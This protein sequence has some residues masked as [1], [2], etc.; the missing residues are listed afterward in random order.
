M[1]LMPAGRGA[2]SAAGKGG[3]GTWTPLNLPALAIWL[4]AND[5]ATITQSTGIVSAWNDKSTGGTYDVSQATS[6]NRPTYNANGL[7]SGKPAIVFASASA[8]KL[9]FPSLTSAGWTSGEILYVVKHTADPPAA[10]AASGSPIC[11][12]NF[13]LNPNSHEPYTDGIC[14]IRGLCSTTRH[15]VG[16]ITPSFASSRIVGVRTGASNDFVYYVDGVSQFTE[17]TGTFDLNME[18]SGLTGACLG[19]QATGADIFF[20][21]ALSEVVFSGATLATLDR[22]KAEGYLAWKWGLT[23]NLDSGHPYKSSAP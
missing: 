12:H 6:G 20:D 7:A 23:A 5:S 17:A 3:G 8:Q 15:V 21:G 18:G 1:I 16:N 4:D 14:Y 13:G 22:Q 11:L 10:D 9:N 19:G 2:I